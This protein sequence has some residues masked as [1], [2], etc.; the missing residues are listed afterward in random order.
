MFDV[1]GARLRLGCKADRIGV[2]ASDTLVITDYKTGATGRVP[3]MEYLRSDLPTFVYYLLAQA[4]YPEYG[5]ARIVFVNVLSLARVEVEY[6]AEQVAANKAGLRECF[7]RL[8]A[9]D[10]FRAKRCEACAWCA[11]ADDCPL[12]DGGVGGEVGETLAQT[13]GSS[14]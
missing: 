7:A 11:V 2:L 3:T 5:A 6:D 8:A 14:R 13:I 9:D 10:G 1:D 4:C 12:F